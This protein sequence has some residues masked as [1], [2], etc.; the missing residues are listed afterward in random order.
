MKQEFANV[1][2]LT[3][4]MNRIAQSLCDMNSGASGDLMIDAISV[5]R[6]N[7]EDN[8]RYWHVGRGFTWMADDE[9]QFENN[10][11]V[12]HYDTENENPYSIEQIK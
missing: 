1:Y 8:I 3:W 6:M 2:D 11:F 12:I 4:A 10:V 9:N 5:N 7:D